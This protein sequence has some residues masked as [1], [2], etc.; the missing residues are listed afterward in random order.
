MKD[1]IDGFFDMD[2]DVMSDE[3]A[4]TRIEHEHEEVGDGDTVEEVYDFLVYEW[5]LP[6]G[7][8]ITARAYTDEMHTISIMTAGP[9]NLPVEVP[10][11]VED[12]LRTRFTAVRVLGPR[13]YEPLRRR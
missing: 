2:L 3:G 7:R 13:G 4:P 10:E 8:A 12:W 1:V 5:D 11:E 6:D 9:G